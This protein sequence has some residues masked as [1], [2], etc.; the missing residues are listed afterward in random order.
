MKKAKSQGV[1][2]S[3]QSNPLNFKLYILIRNDLPSMNA[4]KAM[5]Q[6]AHASNQFIF[7]N[8][9]NKSIGTWQGDRGFGTTIV[10]AVD[11]QT[12]MERISKARQMDMMASVVDDETY[13]FAVNTEIAKLIPHDKQTAP[14]IFKE[15]GLVVLFRREMTCGYIFINGDDEKQFQLVSD[16]PLHL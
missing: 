15:N 1:L 11:I 13:P 9:F 6:A 16:L 5:A 12:L 14:P 3:T 7:E 2:A 10:L 8:P 4:G